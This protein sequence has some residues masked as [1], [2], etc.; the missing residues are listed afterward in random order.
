MAQLVVALVTLAVVALAAFAFATVRDRQK[1]VVN[2]YYEAVTTSHEQFLL[3]VDAESAV[4]DYALSGDPSTL[5]PIGELQGDNA[6]GPRLRQL[7]SDDPEAL[8]ALQRAIDATR[9]WWEQWA[10][11]TITDVRTGG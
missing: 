11:S 2:A 6:A 4:R 10:Q 7:L 8:A 5:A 3:L 9:V 1:R